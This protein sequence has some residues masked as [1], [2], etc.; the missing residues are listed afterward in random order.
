MSSKDALGMIKILAETGIFKLG[1]SGGEPLLR[2]DIF[3]IIKCARDYGIKITLA[4]NGIL[5]SE[6][7]AQMFHK[8]E[9]YPAVSLEGA[10]ES[11]H[12]LLRGKTFDSVIRG[13]HNLTKCDVPFFILTTLTKGNEKEILK[14]YHILERYKGAGLTLNRLIPHGRARAL[15]SIRL[16]PFD[17][18]KILIKICDLQKKG[19]KIFVDESLKPLLSTIT[20]IRHE[21]PAGKFTVSITP[22]GRL[23]PCEALKEFTCSQQ[24]KDKETLLYE[25]LMC[26]ALKTIRHFDATNISQCRSCKYFDLCGGGCRAATYAVNGNLIAPDPDCWSKGGDLWA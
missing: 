12:A 1:I 20:S 3:D 14:I 9:I 24:F 21:C 23:Q 7:V 16:S 5:I 17:Y 2:K 8:L 6:F 18:K 11:T 19:C 26:T 13:I 4:T 25:W 10:R 22:D 15:N